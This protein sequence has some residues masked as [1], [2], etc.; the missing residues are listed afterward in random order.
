[1]RKAPKSWTFIENTFTLGEQKIT[2]NLMLRQNIWIGGDLKLEHA[3]NWQ[4]HQAKFACPNARHGLPSMLE[5]TF[6][7]LLDL[8]A[9]SLSDDEDSDNEA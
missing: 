2:R 9:E 5:N 7:D 4:H 6:G 8:P 1:M 3:M